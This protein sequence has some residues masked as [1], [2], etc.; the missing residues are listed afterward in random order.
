MDARVHLFGVRHH[1]PGSAASLLAALARTDPAAVL[2]EGPSDANDLLG[3]A[4][5]PGM[6]PPVALLVH[7][8]DEPGLASFFP[9]ASFSPEWQALLWALKRQRPVR[10]I[11]WPAAH[12][13]ALRKEREAE[14]AQEAPDAEATPPQTSDPL[15]AIAKVAGH[16]DGEA[17]WNAL[18]ESAG[19]GPDV[20]PVIEAAM[21]E[22]RRAQDPA[23][24]LRRREDDARREAFMRLEI[25][26][27]EKEIEGA[28]AVVTGAWHVP[29]LR[30]AESTANDRA[31]L[32][33]LPRV[34]TAATWVP[35]TEPR[36][37][38]GSGY[39]AGVASPAWYG[40]LWSQYD[41]TGLWPSAQEMAPSWLARVAALLRAEG[42]PASTASVIEAARLSIALAS[43]RGH[44]TPGLTEMRDA[45]LAA[46]CHGDEAPFRM[47]EARLVIGDRVGRIDE[48]VPQ[49]PLAA[50][51]ARWQRRT[52][53]VPE[54]L[55]SEIALD[56]RSEAGLLKSTLLHRLDLIAVPWGRLIDAEAGRG[57]FREVWKL[58]WQPEFSV[59]LAEAL[60]HG[61]T[62]AEAAAGAATAGAAA[63]AGIAELTRL[64][65]QCLL[66]DL[67]VAAEACIARLQSAAVNAADMV[68]LAGSVPPLV[69]ILRYGTA[70]K[71]P[72]D[73][74][75]A[76]THALAVE[77]IAGGTVAS[78]NLDEEAAGR[79]CAAFAAFDA[80]LDLF[81]AQDLIE[82]WCRTLAA[83]V[84]DASAAPVIA[85]FA[86]R[87]LY[88]RSA[89][90]AEATAAALARAL[91]PAN[92]PK[93]AGAFLGGFFGQ[94]AEVILHDTRLFAIIDDWLVAPPEQDFLEI[95]PMIRRA[96]SGFG[97]VERRRLLE[98]VGRDAP[99]RHAV[100]TDIDEE[101]FAKA[102]P[103]LRLIMGID[104]GA[105]G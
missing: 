61:P 65:R 74:L 57:T 92:P 70:R 69:S 86:T 71:I 10:F 45:T 80:A 96:F 87:R 56:L 93:S 79:L 81:G 48:N 78:R 98:Q 49:M 15:D 105:S 82:G 59:R 75:A 64:V 28:L 62:V 60:V 40:H 55:E 24:G 25:R 20:F 67:P 43:L 12:A 4:A 29:A 7:A 41:R 47:I 53:L 42:Q 51:L 17:F 77:V 63:S 50:D 35:W 9:F 94:N 84:A 54:A 14:R 91:S 32:R 19:G 13:L 100:E 37:A 99:T 97:A 83:L 44:A 34:K 23:V 66:A 52:R 68:G 103:L 26:R 3:L 46:L 90:T 6:Q 85:G 30:A 72:E 11:D 38:F 39:G 58:C 101:A 36:L 27:A 8:V 104:D 1:G 33:G 88:E 95:L 102:L 73:A 5:L 2:I 22:L 89:A 21:T 16:S 18:V 76:L 31:L